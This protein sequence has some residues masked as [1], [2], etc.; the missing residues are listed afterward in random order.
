MEYKH[1]ELTHA[2]IGC[3]MQVHRTLGAGFPEVVYQ[4]SLALELEAAGIAFQR[5]IVMPLF[6]RER[7]VGSRR[8]DFMIE[9]CVL[10]ELKAVSEITP[11]HQQQII[12]YLKAYQLE[13]GLL[14]NFGEASLQFRRFIRTSGN[15]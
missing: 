4:R 12:N 3:A 15:A 9:G 1:K 2:V 7:E 10:V 8:A 13:I 14:L 6:Y 5:E 11:L